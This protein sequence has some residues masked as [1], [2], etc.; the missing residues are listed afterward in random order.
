[1]SQYLIFNSTNM[2]NLWFMTEANFN[3]TSNFKQS[4]ENLRHRFIND[5]SLWTIVRLT[6][7]L[8]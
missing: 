8:C 1:M 7:G 2:L 6:L 4:A 3:Q 5:E